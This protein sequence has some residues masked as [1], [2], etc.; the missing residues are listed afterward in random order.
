MRVIIAGAG[1]VGRGV[2]AALRQERRSVALIDPDPSAINE[3]QYLDCL[4]IT[5]SALSRDSLMRAGISDAEI[6]IM[7]TN[8]DMINLLGCSFAK[9]VYSELV[10]ERNATGLRTIANIHDPGLEHPSS[11]AGPLSNWTRADHIVSAA[12]EIVGQ[13]AASLLAPSIDEILPL[14]ES[15]WIASTEVTNSSALIGTTTGEVGGIFAGMPSIYSIKKSD[16]KGALSKGDEIIEPGDILVF[17][18][19]STDQFSQITRSV[20]KSD[21]DLKEKAQIA[22][23]CASQFGVRLSDYYLRRGHSVVVI[24][25]E[26]DLANELVGSS[27]GNSK[28]LD[29]IHGDPQ[30]EDLLREL[31]IHSHDIAVAALED[32]NLNIAIS[33]RAKDKGVLRTGLVLRDRALVDAVQRI[34]SINPV[35]RRQVV[36]TGILKS[37]HMNVPGTFQ[38]IPNVPEVISISAEVKAE[39]GIEGWS[40]SKIESKFGARIAMIDR[41]DFDGKVSV[42]DPNEVDTILLGDRL[43][44]LLLKDDLKKLEK[45]LGS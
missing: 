30:D 31:D 38:V 5:G 40:I 39:Q 45:I 12:D 37:I 34:G 36:V 24:E 43:Y 21:P 15:S 13:L 17:V 16:E 42:L 19:N 20:G 8:D 35:S 33:M 7:A 27:V 23:F 28:R 3:S 25:P 11:G 22:V 9:K 1:E 32:D 26:L 41:E 14:G 44:I 29:V 18:S 6:F 2:A 10:G 4:L